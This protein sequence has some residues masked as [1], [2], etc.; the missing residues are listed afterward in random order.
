MNQFKSLLPSL[1]FILSATAIVSCNQNEKKAE[2]QPTSTS[3]TSPIE[4]EWV[5][6]SADGKITQFKMWHDGFYSLIMQ[7]SLGKWTAAAAGSYSIDGNTYK[8]TI[9]YHSNPEYVGAS[10]WQTFELKGDTLYFRGFDKVVYADGS[11]K[12]SQFDNKF[13]EKRVRANK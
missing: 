1:L 12:T 3:S 10:D 9:H 4:G 8:E 13:E 5:T 6:V 11:D 7:D 2:S